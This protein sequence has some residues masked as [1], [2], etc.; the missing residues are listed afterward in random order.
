MS[1]ERSSSRPSIAQEKERAFPN[2]TPTT[3]FLFLLFRS[4]TPLPIKVNGTRDQTLQRR[5]LDM[6]RRS[7]R[8]LDYESRRFGKNPGWHL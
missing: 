7:G 5:K 4:G 8:I 6:P 3:H 2:T 1:E